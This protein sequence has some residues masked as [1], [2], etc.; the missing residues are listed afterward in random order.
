MAHQVFDG[1]PDRSDLN[2]VTQMARAS[3]FFDRHGRPA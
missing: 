2:R 1:I 3:V